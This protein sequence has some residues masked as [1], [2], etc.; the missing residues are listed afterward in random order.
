MVLGPSTLEKRRLLLRKS[1][2]YV[3]GMDRRKMARP[4]GFEPP[5]CGLE[6]RCSILLSYGRT[7]YYLIYFW[8]PFQGFIMPRGL[9]IFQP[10][11][12]PYILD[13]LQSLLDGKFCLVRPLQQRHLECL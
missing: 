11:M 9:K 4:G 3:S 5:T 8:H 10:L 7:P 13:L 1:V 2:T 12:Q 6:G